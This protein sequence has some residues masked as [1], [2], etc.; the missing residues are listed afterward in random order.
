LVWSR[1]RNS[2][3]LVLEILVSFIVLFVVSAVGLPYVYRIRQPLGFSHDHLYTVTV[4]GGT[5][6]DGGTMVEQKARA[7]SILDELRAMPES[8]AA[9]GISVAPFEMVTATYD[10]EFAGKTV[11]GEAIDV[12]DEANEALKIHVVRGRWFSIS[13]D[14]LDWT[15]IV[16]NRMMAERLFGGG[17]PIGHTVRREPWCRVI[18]VVD[19]F[20]RGGS[21]APLGPVS[22]RRI[23]LSKRYDTVPRQFVVRVRPQ[24]PVTFEERALRGVQR[25]APGW[26]FQVEP[27]GHVRQRSLRLGIAPLTVAAMVAGFLMVM[28]VLGMIGVFWLSVTRRAHE[29]GLRRAFGGARETIYCQLMVEILILASVGSGAAIAVIVQLPLLGLF[30]GIGVGTFLGALG[31]SLVLT[32][33]LA[34]IS[35]LYPA[36]LAARVQPAQ[37]L[38]YE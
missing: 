20:R 16:I 13:D 31:L 11:E 32:Y 3:L 21:L 1:K 18:G 23:S 8:V 22:I 37:A 30:G 6:L 34:L 7:Q 15:P 27:T 24:T 5:F 28:V 2:G 36:W 12:T 38:H 9:A 25:A 33:V 14:T 35:G 4:Q 29:I 26:K 17:D 19:D 10:L